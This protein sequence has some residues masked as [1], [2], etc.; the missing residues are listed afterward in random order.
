VSNPKELQTKLGYHFKN[1]SLLNIA[2]THPSVSQEKKQIEHNQRLEFLGD[3]VIQLVLSHELFKRFPTYNEGLLTKTRARLVN[4]RTLA[5]ISRQLGLGPY[6][7]MSKGEESHGGRDRT[8]IL[9]DAFEAII[10][11]IYLDGG[12][13]AASNF[14]LQHFAKYLDELPGTPS[15]WNPKGELQEYLQAKSQEPPVYK[16]LSVRGPDH[17]REFECM[18]LH[19]GIPLATGKGKSKKAAEAEAAYL[20]LKKLRSADS[21]TESVHAEKIKKQT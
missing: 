21:E 20:A 11:A 13:Q 15:S 1:A 4:R 7:I 2:L 9:A 8:S 17:D 3:A 5:E 19:Q 16:L 18:V 6:L 12:L 14:I 10:G